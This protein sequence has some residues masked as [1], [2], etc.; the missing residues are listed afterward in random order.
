MFHI[1]QG[2]GSNGS[3]SPNSS[4]YGCTKYALVQLAHTLAVECKN[5]LVGIH[6]LQPGMVIT[7]LLVSG[8]D[9]S[10][11]WIMN[12]LAEEPE[13]V[14]KYLVSKVSFVLLLI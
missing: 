5:S 6:R 10:V 2:R 8:V 1:Q 9:K 4:I 14:A 11:H 3:T 13:V 12:T 7:E